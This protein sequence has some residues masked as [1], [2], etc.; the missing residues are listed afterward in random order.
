MTA[1]FYA[2][3]PAPMSLKVAVQMDPLESITI[4][5]NNLKKM[6]LIG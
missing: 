5:W 3:K 1:L 4:S 6:D 2:T